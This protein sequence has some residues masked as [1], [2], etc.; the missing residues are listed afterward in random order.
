MKVKFQPTHTTN[1]ITIWLL[2]EHLRSDTYLEWNEIKRHFTCRF[3]FEQSKIICVAIIDSIP[4]DNSLFT[5]IRLS[6][7]KL[8]LTILKIIIKKPICLSKILHI[9]LK[10]FSLFTPGIL[11]ILIIYYNKRLKQSQQN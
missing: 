4:S 9:S 3:E 5:T 7:C 6:I 11:L 2:I 10:G 1:L 8:D